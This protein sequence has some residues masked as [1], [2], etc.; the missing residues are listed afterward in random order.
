MNAQEI[1]QTFDLVSYVSVSLHK[2]GA[3]FIGAC[4]ICGGRDRFQIKRTSSGD[5]WICRKCSPDKYHSVIDFLMSYH[6]ENFKDALKRAGGD[7]QS[8]RELGTG[9]PVTPPAPV[10]VLP[11]AE[12]QAD[13]WKLIEAANRKLESEEDGQ[14]YLL[15]RGISRASMNRFLLGFAVIGKRPAIVIPYCDIG[16]IVTAVKYRYIDELSQQ[17]KSKRFAM[18]TGSMPFLFG[19]EHI[20]ESDTTLLFV[21]GEL[22]AISIL[23]TC[24][25][26]VSVVSAGS[27]GNGNAALIK[28]LARHYNRVV[29]W[30]DDPA[31][32]K[33][34]RDRMGRQEARLLKSPV[35][36]GTKYDANQMLQV[37]LLMDFVSAELATECQGGPVEM[38]LPSKV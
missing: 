36:D 8:R 5:V 3:Y 31:K 7:V 37:G 29:I 14:R 17:D 9:K 32:G 30:T 34:I 24:P 23:Q 1:N 35:I 6:K 33:I 4:P 19:C 26:G 11:S 38:L 28:A 10:Q 25:R 18:M 13:A 27:E 15:G 2:S 16:D 20:L 12:W 22:N 21:E